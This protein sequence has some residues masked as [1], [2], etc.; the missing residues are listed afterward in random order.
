MYTL[1]PNLPD[2]GMVSTNFLTTYNWVPSPG[3]GVVSR[4][5]DGLLALLFLALPFLVV[6]L[7]ADLVLALPVFLFL[8]GR[9]L[10]F[11]VFLVL[12]FGR[13]L[14]GR[15]LAVAFAFTLAGL[16]LD[17]SRVALLRVFRRAGRVSRVGTR[18]V[19]YSSIHE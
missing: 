15:F 4:A 19:V 14:A 10:V 8:A 1:S 13:F 2:G 9:V 12:V 11:L 17:R 3:G 16:A 6:F 18:V 5:A 7:L